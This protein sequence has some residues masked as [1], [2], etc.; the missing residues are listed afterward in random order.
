[1]RGRADRALALVAHAAR[2]GV[3]ARAAV[4]PVVEQ[5]RADRLLAARV[6]AG[7]RAGA[8]VHRREVR[9]DAGVAVLR[10]RAGVTAGAAV[11]V[12]VREVVADRSPRGAGAG[13]DARG[14]AATGRA[15]AAVGAGAAAAAR[16][17]AAVAR[18]H[19]RV[20]HHDGARALALLAV[21]AG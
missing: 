20:D 10:R 6:E 8:A 19:A 5:H 11:R 21:H 12:I 9:A 14:D 16:V 15:G 4:A 18:R 7:R 3:A 1:A 2:A 17:A 13:L